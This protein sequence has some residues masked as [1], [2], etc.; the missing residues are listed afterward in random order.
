[1]RNQ[2]VLLKGVND[3]SDVLA[4]LMNRLVSHGVIPYY[5][6][7]CRPAEGVKNQFQVP[8]LRGVDI[9]QNARKKING[10]AK[11]F[12]FAFSHPSGK[13]EIVGK[14]E[15]NSIVFKYHQAK[16]DKDNGRVFI[17]KTDENQCWLDEI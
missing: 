3:D 17:R 5:I 9:V 12:H 1:M 8:L 14:T 10:Q 15:D 13:I 4:E 2:T 6:F 7:Q 16:Y 11:S